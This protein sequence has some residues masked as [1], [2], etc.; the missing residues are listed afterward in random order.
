MR[1]AVT[2]VFTCGD[3]LFVIRR[4]PWLRAFPGYLAFPGGKIDDQDQ[5]GA[6]THPLVSGFPAAW[7]RALY[8]EIREELDYDLEAALDRGEIE[9]VDRVGT[10][11]TPA[12]E[13]YRFR[14]QYF[15]IQLRQR[16]GFRPDREEIAWSDWVE[17][18]Q[19]W[20]EFQAGRHL[21]VAPTR[22]LVRALALDPGV[23]RVEP[24]NISYI[25]G[26]T[27]PVLELIAGI[28]YIPVPSNTL[29]PARFTNALLLGD[30]G[31]RRCLVD[32]SPES[33]CVLEQLLRTLES[34]PVDALMITHHHPDHHQFAPDI[35]RRLSLPL[36]CSQRTE[37]RLLATFGEHYLDGLK[38]QHLAEGDRLTRWL[39]RS[40]ICHELPGH[41]DG[42]LGL[43]PEQGPWFFVSDLVQTLGTVVIP[44][45]EG[46]MAAYFSSLQRVIGRAPEMLI[47]SHGLP[48][49]GTW[50]LQR[51]LQHRMQ[52]EQ[53]VQRLHDAGEGLEEIVGALYPELDSELRPLAAQ[54]VRQHLRKLG[55][56]QGNL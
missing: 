48:A 12:F 47:P 41:D 9:S 42:M 19:L 27:L 15:R 5:Q 1:E 26:R 51:T 43:A 31:Q 46:D 8:R 24:F 37:R 6:C 56:G 11:I 10:A 16:P 22:N 29:P 53:Q 54:N 38:I 18:R 3:D 14:V 49:G 21:M 30:S 50:H 33:E 44:E 28:G 40:V 20:Q 55:L 7:I 4:Q 45:P 34:H 2:A 25:E 36:L 52:R 35:A 23:S 13:R 39:G 17:R 32:P